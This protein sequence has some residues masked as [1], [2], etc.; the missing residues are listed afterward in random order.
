MTVRDR[1]VKP[2]T[3]ELS[4]EILTR[5]LGAHG[6]ANVWTHAVA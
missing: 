5:R 1:G 6:E 4:T 2:V 3:G